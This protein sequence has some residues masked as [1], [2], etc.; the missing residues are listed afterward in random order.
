MG[1]VAVMAADALPG[2]E[3]TGRVQRVGLEAE[4]WRSDEGYEQFR[5]P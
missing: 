2:L 1:Q 5:V 3:L 4:D